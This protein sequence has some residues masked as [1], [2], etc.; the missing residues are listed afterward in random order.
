[1]TA[2]AAIQGFAHQNLKV[3]IG[4][5]VVWTNRD[6]AGHTTT[7]GQGQW[8]SGRLQQGESFS[9]TFTELGVFSYFCAIH[10]SMTAEVTVTN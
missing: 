9:F 3:Q 1:M 5:T 10:R 6:G 8:D 4:T 2:D 7:A